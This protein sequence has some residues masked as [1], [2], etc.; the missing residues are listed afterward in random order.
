MLCNNAAADYNKD[1]KSNNDNKHQY[2]NAYSKYFPFVN[3]F[4]PHNNP[5]R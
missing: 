1:N 4:N 2:N 3:S 5:M